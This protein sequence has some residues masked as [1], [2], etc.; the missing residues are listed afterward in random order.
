MNIFFH[1]QCVRSVG[2]WSIGT[3]IIESSIQNAYLQMIDAAEHYIY[4]EVC[5]E[6][7][8]KQKEENNHFRINFLLQLPM[9]QL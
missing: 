8:R 9:M 6:E 1:F 2:P 5:E 7:K 3:K 4:M